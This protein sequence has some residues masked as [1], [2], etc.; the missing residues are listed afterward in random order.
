MEKIRVGRIVWIA[1]VILVIVLS[2]A[3]ARFP[4]FPGDVA[5]AKL[6]QSLA[7]ES[8]NWAEWITSTAKAPWSLVLL[9]MSA[10]ISSRIARWPAAI[11]TALSFLLAWGLGAWLNPLVARPRPTSELIHVVGSPSGYSF[12]STF[13]LTYAATLG[14]LAVLAALKSRGGPR[15]AALITCSVLLAIGGWARIALGAHWPSDI[16]ISY[17]MGVL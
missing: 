1:L 17:L 13:A 5:F 2:L 6:L 8:K 12:P 3:T 14:F 16:L 9:A 10:L 15:W 11:L 7:P 4:Y